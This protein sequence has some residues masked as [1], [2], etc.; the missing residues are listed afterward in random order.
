MILQACVFEIVTAQVSQIPVPD[1]AFAAPGS[2][3]GDAELPLRP[4]CSIPTDGAGII[5]G[6]TP[7]VPDVSR[8]ENEALVFYFLAASY[9]E[10]GNRGDPLRAGRADETANDPADPSS[11]IRKCSH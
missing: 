8:P 1:W 6:G 10:P 3:G 7:S 9:I 11:I 2:A 4:R 5:G